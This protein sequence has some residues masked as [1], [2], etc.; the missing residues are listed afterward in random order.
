MFSMDF[1][2]L[3]QELIKAMHGELSS[4][5][6]YKRL[7]DCSEDKGD[8]E[9]ISCFIKDE[10]KHYN[11]FY[12]LYIKLTGYAPVISKLKIPE[13]ANYIEGITQA[14]KD[15]AD[16]FEFYRNIFIT[17]KNPEIRDIFLEAFTDES[18]HAIKLNYLH[19]KNS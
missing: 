15:E 5:E 13:F 6:Y 12:N 10:S 18:K 2:Y 3:P 14:I 4:K 8:K 11:N 9:I 16:A 17:Y 1:L 7:V 19:T